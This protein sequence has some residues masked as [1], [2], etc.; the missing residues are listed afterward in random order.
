MFNKMREIICIA[1]AIGNGLQALL[2]RRILNPSKADSALF[3]AVIEMFS[4]Q[5]Y[6][7]AG[8]V[9]SDLIPTTISPI[10]VL[11]ISSSFIVI[12]LHRT[13]QC[14][15]SCA[16]VNT[17]HHR[18]HFLKPN[19]IDFIVIAGRGQFRW[20]ENVILRNKCRIEDGKFFLKRPCKTQS[21][22]Q[23]QCTGPAYKSHISPCAAVPIGC[24][25]YRS[26]DRCQDAC[27]QS[28]R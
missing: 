21:R 12:I 6:K 9:W 17:A 11:A 28:V 8:I 1:I 14:L 3:E 2:V 13:R 20:W 25:P 26:S 15:T 16:P 27:R 19:Q 7:D 5:L 10:G 23:S 4:T 22:P 18:S 24:R